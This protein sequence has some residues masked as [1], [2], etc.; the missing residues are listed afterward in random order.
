MTTVHPSLCCTIEG[1]VRDL[2]HREAERL[3]HEGP[4]VTHDQLVQNVIALVEAGDSAP[5]ALTSAITNRAA[6]KQKLADDI[7]TALQQLATSH[8][9]YM[10]PSQPDGRFLLLVA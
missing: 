6:N 5:A 8:E 10:I 9:V 1:Y 3:A 2:T 7:D 4:L